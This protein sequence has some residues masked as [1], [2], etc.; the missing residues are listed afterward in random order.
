VPYSAKEMMV[1]P[2]SLMVNKPKNYGPKCI[3]PVGAEE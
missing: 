2:V 3:A 1:S